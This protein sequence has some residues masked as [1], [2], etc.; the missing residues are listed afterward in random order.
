MAFGPKNNKIEYKI[1][2]M[3]LFI[4]V[5]NCSKEAV[6]NCDLQIHMCVLFQSYKHFFYRELTD[7]ENVRKA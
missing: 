2:V 3:K 4:S 1:K 5:F 7:Q 6:D